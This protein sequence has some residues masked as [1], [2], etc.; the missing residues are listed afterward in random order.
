MNK[1]DMNRAIICVPCV[2]INFF[3]RP[4]DVL[5]TFLIHFF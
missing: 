5:L 3:S 4:R 1:D 2:N